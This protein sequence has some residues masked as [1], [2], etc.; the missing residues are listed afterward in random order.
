MSKLR[1]ATEN[2]GSQWKVE[3]EATLVRLIMVLSNLKNL[4]EVLGIHRHLLLSRIRD[5]RMKISTNNRSRTKGNKRLITKTIR[6]IASQTK[7]I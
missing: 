6:K 5:M 7:M 2:G 1:I 4:V 3:M